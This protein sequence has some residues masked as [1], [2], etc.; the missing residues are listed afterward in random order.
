MIIRILGEPQH[1]RHGTRARLGVRVGNILI[2]HEGACDAD[3]KIDTINIF[4]V[5]ES[6]YCRAKT[7]NVLNARNFVAP[8]ACPYSDIERYSFMFCVCV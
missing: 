1:I 6:H 5:M 4:P 2:M 7:N 8:N 3:V